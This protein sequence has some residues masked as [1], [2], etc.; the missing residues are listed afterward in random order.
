MST[1]KYKKKLRKLQRR[2]EKVLGELLEVRP[3]LKGTV[4]KIYTRCGKPNCWCA[5]GP[6]GHAHIRISWNQ[7]SKTVT[8]KIPADK[9]SRVRNL[10]DNYRHFRSLRR[11]LS[12]LNKQIKKALDSYQT[13]LVEDS[14]AGMPFLLF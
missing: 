14:R 7:N 13:A 1:E 8:R 2:Q 9:L 10:T 4:N 6:G 3:I 12:E 5:N 11:Q